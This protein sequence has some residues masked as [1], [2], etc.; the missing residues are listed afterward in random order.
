MADRLEV[1]ERV[2][3]CDACPLHEQGPVPFSGPVPAKVA[4]VGEAPEEG[5]TAP[6]T[7]TAGQLLRSLLTEVGIDVE[8]VFFCNTVSCSACPPA[9]ADIFSCTP[10]RLA[11]I[12]LAQP[13]YV[14][15][16]GGT[17][18]SAW[19]P[20]VP[21]KKAHGRAFCPTYPE[22]PVYFPVYHPAAA[23]ANKLF[24]RE[25]RADLEKFAAMVT[26][27]RVRLLDDCVMCGRPGEQME[28]W[29]CDRSGYAFCE[30][31]FHHCPEEYR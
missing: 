14:L 30:R 3:T 12:E 2:L 10:N 7:G 25:L 9:A 21:I 13:E 1:L 11:Q 8:Q 18:L 15:L 4:V 28:M 20:Y 23:L 31:C 22:P 24:E 16:A 27:D 6:M 5:E 17:A 19:K 26:T 29:R